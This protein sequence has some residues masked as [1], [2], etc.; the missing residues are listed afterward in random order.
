V[1]P[2]RAA[3]AITSEVVEAG[4]AAAAQ[5]ACKARKRRIAMNVRKM[6]LWFVLVDFAAL[7]TWSLWQV[8]YVGIWQAG[9]ASPGALQ[10]LADL[11][12]SVGLVC[13]WMIADA[14]RRGVVAWPWVTATLLLGSLA[15]LLYLIRREGAVR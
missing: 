4:R 9:L 11:G 6:L 15:P 5:C 14:R 2:I 8:G 7:T 12:I 10:V 3:Q 1:F 13:T